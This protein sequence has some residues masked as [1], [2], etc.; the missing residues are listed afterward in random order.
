MEFQESHLREREILGK[1]HDLSAS[2]DY[3]YQVSW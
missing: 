1:G 3:L 2:F